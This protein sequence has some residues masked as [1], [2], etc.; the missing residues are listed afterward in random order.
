MTP[1]RILRWA[2]AVLCSAVVLFTLTVASAAPVTVQRSEAAR[3]RLSWNARPE[4]IEICRTL[5]HEELEKL[6][7]HMR[8]RVQCEGRFATCELRLEADG[9]VTHESVVRGAGLRH[10]RPL[11][12]L[13][14]IDIAPGVHRIRVL[15]T[16]RERA[17]ADRATPERMTT[18]ELD[19]GLFAGRAQ[20]EAAERARR[21]A[22]AIPPRLELDTTVIFIANNVFVVSLDAERRVL[23]LLGA[24]PS[25]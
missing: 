2:I 23:R 20:R 11:Y 21:A 1:R 19:T 15:F 24:T 7:E 16:R 6:E 9:R 3:L 18:T 25:R 17:D 12:L 10:D 5:S 4:R 13:R 14:E 8:Q 22:A